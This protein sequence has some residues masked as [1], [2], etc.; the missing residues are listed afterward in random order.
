MPSARAASSLKRRKLR[1]LNLK[2]DS[3]SKCCLSMLPRGLAIAFPSDVRTASNVAA[4][5][6]GPQ[7]VGEL[8][9]AFVQE[10]RGAI[11]QAGRVDQ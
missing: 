5:N 9:E 7:G 11:K 1:S 4:R 2:S 6:C 10:A 3:A 8:A